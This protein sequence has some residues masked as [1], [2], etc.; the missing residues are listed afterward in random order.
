MNNEIPKIFNLH[1]PRL[2][3]EQRLLHAILWRSL[4]DLFCS[5]HLDKRCALKF[6]TSKKDKN[7]PWSFRWICHEIE[8]CPE[9][10]RNHILEYRNKLNESYLNDLLMGR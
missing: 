1:D 3:P 8:I 4:K 6:I 9:K 10:I 2:T 7:H 5:T